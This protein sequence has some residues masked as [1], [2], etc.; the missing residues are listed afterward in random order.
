MERVALSLSFL[1]PLAL[2]IH[3]PSPSLFLSFSSNDLRENK[4]SRWHL[5]SCEPKIPKPGSCSSKLWRHRASL[6]LHFAKL[7]P[8]RKR[9]ILI[10]YVI[11]FRYARAF[12]P[13]SFS[14]PLY[15]TPTASLRSPPSRPL[16][17]PFLRNIFV[18]LT[19]S[20]FECRR[21]P[22]RKSNRAAKVS[23]LFF[24]SSRRLFFRERHL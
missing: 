10:N 2:L 7:V 13:S 6:S 16:S 20:F 15:R 12:S 3:S 4:Y 22:S 11:T 9:A 24:F 23:F 14:F 1:F 17:L 19:P 8:P 21:H 5:N 18:Q